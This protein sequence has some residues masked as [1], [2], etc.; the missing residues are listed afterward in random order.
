MSD[1]NVNREITLLKECHCQ[2]ASLCLFLTSS[3]CFNFFSP[4]RADWSPI[5]LKHRLIQFV[6]LCSI[7]LHQNTVQRIIPV[8]EAFSSHCDSIEQLPKKHRFDLL[9]AL[10]HIFLA[11]TRGKCISWETEIERKVFTR[12][13]FVDRASIRDIYRSIV[14]SLAVEVCQ[15]DRS[16]VLT[17]LCASRV[18]NG[19]EIRSSWKTERE[20]ERERENDARRN[21][22]S[23]VSF[24]PD[25]V[26]RLGHWLREASRCVR[27]SL[28]EV[29]TLELQRVTNPIAPRLDAQLETVCSL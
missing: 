3:R 26:E 6:F 27:L 7:V 1:N 8:F 23:Q 15:G 12:Y 10:L 24:S 29:N 19:M 25:G 18:V 16:R 17:L 28:E 20:R 11:N 2:K 5:P 14:V 13:R 22:F 9:A 21:D 4:Q